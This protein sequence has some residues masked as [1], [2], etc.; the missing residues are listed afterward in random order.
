VNSVVARAA[1]RIPNACQSRNCSKEGCKISMRGLD[2]PRVLIDMDCEQLSIPGD[3]AH[4]DYIFVGTHRGNEW[5]APME[6][7]RGNVSVGEL[8]KQLQAGADFA[9]SRL[10]PQQGQ[11]PQQEQAVFRPIAAYG[12]KLHKNQRTELKKGLNR[13]KFGQ[14]LYQIKLIRCGSPLV[15]ALNK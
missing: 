14:I 15:K 12:G 10:L 5:I 7:K 8:R 11:V 9:E 1:D 2:D 4:C 13:V 6:L 3:Q